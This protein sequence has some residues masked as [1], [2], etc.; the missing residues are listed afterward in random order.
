MCSDAL[1]AHSCLPWFVI[2]QNGGGALLL[3]AALQVRS[4]RLES[5]GV[6]VHC[7]HDQYIVFMP[8]HI[9]H[10]FKCASKLLSS[11]SVVNRCRSLHITE[12]NQH[13]NIGFSQYLQF[14]D[15][16]NKQSFT[17]IQNYLS[18][19]VQLLI[20][21]FSVTQNNVKCL[22]GDVLIWSETLRKKWN[23]NY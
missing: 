9:V 21:K 5:A 11:Y 14:I 12:M 2:M 16:K 19:C 10:R 7:N 23:S 3:S 20:S 4:H 13:I 1:M 17:Y 8:V 15:I 6:V 18:C 22:W